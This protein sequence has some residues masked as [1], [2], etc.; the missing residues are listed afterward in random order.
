MRGIRWWGRLCLV[1]TAVAIVASVTFSGDDPAQAAPDGR[2]IGS[3]AG[4]SASAQMLWES[5]SELN[6]E[7]DE[8]ARSGAKWLR[9]DFNWPSVQPTPTSWNW[10]ATDRIVQEASSRGMRILAMPAYTP[11][12]ARGPGTDDKY[13]PSDRGTYA[14]FVQAA[15]RR[16]ESVVKHWEIWN[17]PNQKY[18]WK[19]RPDPWAYT[20]LLRRTYSAVKAEDPSATVVAGGLAPAPDASDGSEINGATFARRMYEAGA[21]GYFDALAMHPYNYPV[22]PMYPHPD[23]AFWST[24]PAIHRVMEQHGDGWKKLW[25]TE[26]GAPTSGNRAVSEQ[27]QG[28]YLIKAYEQAVRWPWAG[29]LLYYMYRDNGWD[30]SDAHDNF[31]LVRRDWTWKRGMSAFRDAMNRPLPPR[32]HVVAG[33]AMAPSTSLM[34]ADRRYTLA[35]QGDGN[36]VIYNPAGVAIWSTGTY[37]H[38]G[39]SLSFQYNGNLVLYNRAGTPLWETMTDG[40]PA[41]ALFMQNDGNLVMYSADRRLLWATGTQGR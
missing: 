38:P 31:G 33:E 23:N 12:W 28:E 37:S 17:E 5:D 11:P 36:L 30:R 3:Y 39:S 8:M 9:I 15:V 26:Y 16:Y 20:D 25:L 29:P 27:L 35:M 7:L 18:W 21:K 14:R 40:Q 4:F 6:R 41:A 19:P 22:E 2:R 34:S 10:Q 32:D 24:T 1:I 13:P